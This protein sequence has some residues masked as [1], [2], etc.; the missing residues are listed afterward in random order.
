MRRLRRIAAPKAF[1]MQLRGVLFGEPHQPD[2]DE[3]WSAGEYITEPLPYLPTDRYPPPDPYRPIDPYRSNDPYRS[4]DTDR[5][6]RRR[7]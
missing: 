4:R 1:Y 6:G 5:R 3:G 2:P 7:G